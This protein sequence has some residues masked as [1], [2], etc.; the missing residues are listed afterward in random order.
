MNQTS[1]YDFTGDDI[2]PTEPATGRPEAGAIEP[3]GAGIR[4][5]GLGAV[6]RRPS[7]EATR[8]HL[9]MALVGLLSLIAL[10]SLC[11]VL[12]EW[13]EVDSVRAILE[14]LFP[15]VVALTG[16]ALGFY[17]G[18]ERGASE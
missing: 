11:A 9:A 18:V 10:L 12:F 15:P 4:L 3:A 5:T 14:V 7:R 16:S 17:F 6:R 8:R 1:D 2:G 13:T